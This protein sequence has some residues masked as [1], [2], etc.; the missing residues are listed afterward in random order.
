[1]RLNPNVTAA[2]VVIAVV[3]A[4]ALAMH[5]VSHRAPRLP[6]AAAADTLAPATQTVS[7]AD[8][9]DAAR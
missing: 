5:H 2:V 6:V 7:P 9:S 8:R 3:I 1:M 4:A